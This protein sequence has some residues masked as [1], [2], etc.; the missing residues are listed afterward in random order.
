M[1]ILKFKETAIQIGSLFF[2]SL[3]T[4]SCSH[5][6]P[7]P[8]LPHT[9]LTSSEWAYEKVISKV[10]SPE[11][12]T[13]LEKLR[14]EPTPH[15]DRIITLNVLG[16]L[17]KSD[18]SL[19]YSKVAVQ[20]CKKLIK[21]YRSTFLGA[22]AKFQVPKEVIAALL[23]VETK[24][25][26]NLGRYSILETYFAL[27]Q[28]DHPTAIEAVFEEL[29]RKLEAT[30]AS[31][32]ELVAKKA[33]DRCT[34]KASWAVEQILAIDEII[35]KHGT[36]ALETKGS[37]AGAFGFSQFIPSSY[38]KFAKHAPG[39]HSR[40]PNLFTEKDA[41]YSVAN[42]LHS[43]GWKTGNEKAQSDALFEY[44]R[45]RAYGEVILKIASEI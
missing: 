37:F 5:T 29:P 25:G 28:S 12:K 23:W 22:E 6:I 10:K 1:M 4:L 21:Y 32:N 26:R 7:I 39:S 2:F 42:F 15:R 19:H 3:L 45:I 31:F 11:L 34:T 9:S 16:F 36:W 24:H 43:N 41:I 14:Q 8:D 17:S 38:L 30:N 35:S 13:R 40:Y 20:E 44:N 33:R 27:A 18:Y